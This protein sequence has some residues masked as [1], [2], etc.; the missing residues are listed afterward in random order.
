MVSEDEALVLQ[1]K[2]DFEDG[3]GPF[4]KE[5]GDGK[6]KDEGEEEAFK[7][8]FFFFLKSPR[9]SVARLSFF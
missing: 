1:A 7:V 3:V 9:S 5:E 6:D 8:W 4:A 2:R